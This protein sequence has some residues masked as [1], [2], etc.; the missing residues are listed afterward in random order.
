MAA[1]TYFETR[2][3]VQDY[4]LTLVEELGVNL[5]DPAMATELDRRDELKSFRE[6]FEVPAIGELLEESH[7]DPG[8]FSSA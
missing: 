6:R 1:A 2:D 7:R 4:L 3:Q 5:E 8:I